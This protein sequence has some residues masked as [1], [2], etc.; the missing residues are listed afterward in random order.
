MTENEEMIDNSDACSSES[1]SSELEVVLDDEG[2]VAGT[3][4]LNNLNFEFYS[5]NSSFTSSTTIEKLINDVNV[6]FDGCTTFWLP[7]HDD[8]KPRTTMERL[9]K[10]IFDFHVTRKLSKAE[11][12]NIDWD[13]SGAEYWVQRRRIFYDAGKQADSSTEEKNRKI[14]SA[15][16]SF[17]KNDS[18][19]IRFHWDKDEE[20][21]DQSD[22]NIVVNPQIS[23]VTYLTDGG[24]PTVIFP[25]C[26]PRDEEHDDDDDDDNEGNND[27]DNCSS[28]EK[29]EINESDNNKTTNIKNIFASYP[30]LAKH[31]SFDGRFL[32]GCPSDLQIIENDNGNNNN[33]DGVRITFLVNM[34]I[35]WRPD[36]E[37]FPEEHISS[38]SNVISTENI[39]QFNEDNTKRNHC[40]IA[41]NDVGFG[42]AK[43]DHSFSILNINEK[44]K[45]DY[46]LIRYMAYFG[47]SAWD[48]SLIFDWPCKSYIKKIIDSNPHLSSLYIE[49]D[50]GQE[51]AESSK[52][53]AV[54]SATQ[55][56]ILRSVP[57][58]E[59][60]PGMTWSSIVQSFEQHNVLLVKNGL[61]MLSSENNKRISDQHS[62]LTK[63]HSSYESFPN[64]L[65]KNWN[66]LF[67]DASKVNPSS[68]LSKRNVNESQSFYS[69]PYDDKSNSNSRKSKRQ[70]KTSID[71]FDKW[72]ASILISKKSDPVVF[73]E[74][75]EKYQ[76]KLNHDFA[77]ADKLEFFFGQNVNCA[78]SKNKKNKKQALTINDFSSSI[79]SCAAHMQLCGVTRWEISPDIDEDWASIIG[80]PPPL[81]LP[82]LDNIVI[83]L[84]E[85]DI[86]LM[87]M[88]LWNCTLKLPDND[89]CLS[90]AVELVF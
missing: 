55:Q 12:E 5:C 57:T 76:V 44:N 43:D 64:V 72:F 81:L 39:F 13:K 6:V 31:I 62:I 19:A 51:N 69:Y 67:G 37:I 10:E 27:N 54:I 52:I 36:I 21:V 1:E 35:N 61:S 18:S 63:L 23:T 41:D 74:M 3:K 70:R 34:W 26:F 24:S 75:L 16:P 71:N 47:P 80:R 53:G 8:F 25:Y 32:H 85:N 7:A 60:C 82:S 22:G 87:N 14:I 45:D 68:T 79:S 29:L 49:Y 2:R 65:E 77:S 33:G 88:K 59:Y 20:L 73:S 38:V 50:G 56:H 66:I 30:K 48:N 58:I 28:D 78:S 86:L 15:S 9:A 46:D 90:L 42:S 89:F 84:K 17:L 11:K 40:V 4:E 83:D